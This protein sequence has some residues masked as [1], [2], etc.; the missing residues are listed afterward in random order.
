MVTDLKIL[1]GLIYEM[2]S[3]MRFMYVFLLCSLIVIPVLHRFLKD[4]IKIWSSVCMIP[5]AVYIIFLCKEQY[6]GNFELTIGR[7]NGKK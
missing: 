2:D 5:L 7:I 6:V 4:H 3:A 1:Y